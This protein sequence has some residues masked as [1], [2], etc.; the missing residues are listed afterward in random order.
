MGSSIMMDSPQQSNNPAE[1]EQKDAE[2][3]ARFFNLAFTT[4]TNYGGSHPSTRTVMEQFFSHIAPLLDKTG[5]IT[6]IMERDSFFIDQWRVDTRINTRKLR[7]VFKK[8]GL[9]SITFERGLIFNEVVIFI[10]LIGT[11][12]SIDSVDAMKDVLDRKG[13]QHIR[14]NYVLYKKVTVDEAVVDKSAV[15]EPNMLG[16]NKPENIKEETIESIGKLFTL[17]DLLERPRNV[18]NDILSMVKNEETGEHSEVIERL[19][20]L[21]SQI[22]Q[23]P[24]EIPFTSLEEVMDAVYRM[25]L[26]LRQSL[27]VH[28]EMGTLLGTQA[29][30]LS[31]IDTMSYNVI[32]QM[33]KE[34]YNHGK[35]SVQRLGQLIRKMM[36]DINDLKK[37]LPRLK[38]ALLAEGMPLSDFLELM[39]ELNNDLTNDNVVEMLQSGAEEIGCSADEIVKG[40]QGNPHEAARLIVLASE[41]KNSGASQS[42][43]LSELLAGYIESV[44]SSMV[45]QSSEATSEQG[46]K[47]LRE[48]IYTLEKQLLENCRSRGI[49]PAVIQQVEKRLSGR[50]Q[51]TLDMLKTKWMT[52]LLEK[53]NDI[54]SSYLMHILENI[55]EQ[56]VDLNT[57]KD[58]LKEILL[59]KGY[60]IAQIEQIYS[61]IASRIT[62]H[63]PQS[64]L[65]SGVLSINN[66][67]FFLKHQI[68]LYT[69][70][71]NPFSCLLFTVP[72]AS[73][74]AALRILS[75]E[76]QGRAMPS[77]YK[78]LFPLIRDLDLI[79]SLGS[80]ERNIPFIILPMTDTTGAA[81]LKKRLEKTAGTCSVSLDNT[82]HTV[83]VVIS[84]T[85]YDSETARDMKQFLL[86]MKRRHREE[87]RKTAERIKNRMSR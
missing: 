60:S 69:R 83:Y 55:V 74:G 2:T 79:G 75:R 25:K 17:K 84:S 78:R 36:P 49:S 80:I 7:G 30:V 34:E 59:H 47:A 64:V 22:L 85:G 39:Q 9:E 77:V 27:A 1:I 52:Q 21:N 51:K 10:A 28:K 26:E 20:D 68:K 5:M 4:S 87:E 54:S 53:G 46:G 72:L 18:T 40:I 70:Y 50:F 35:I 86:L 8:I 76:E 63:E 31:E 48:M 6:L 19:H 67:I 66:T 82:E 65:P 11:S 41:I 43:A 12:Q 32:I 42:G 24:T 15:Y 14:P 81:A 3:V 56:E 71:G 57:I 33:V 37:L 13:V 29:D 73:D 38:E 45:L 62:L 58:P 23:H 16:Q 61:Q 44:S